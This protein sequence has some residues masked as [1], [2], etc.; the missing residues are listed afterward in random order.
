MTKKGNSDIPLA[1][2]QEAMNQEI[3]T[4]K[5]GIGG[6]GTQ[7]I[8]VFSPFLCCPGTLCLRLEHGKLLD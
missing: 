8:F 4:L 2:S 6:S 3:T 7:G 1:D 5:G